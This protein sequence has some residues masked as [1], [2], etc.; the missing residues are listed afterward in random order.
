MNDTTH[1]PSVTE[2]VQSEIPDYPAVRVQVEGPVRAQQPGSPVC[3]AGR[4]DLDTKSVRVLPPDRRRRIVT[5]IGVTDVIWVGFQQ[6]EADRQT[7]LR[8]PVGVPWP[9]TGTDEIWARADADAAIL[10]W[11][12][13]LWTE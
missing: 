12:A 2:I 7:G 1:E 8:L 13:E 10:T 5:L 9:I 6:S 3:A 11:T 4:V